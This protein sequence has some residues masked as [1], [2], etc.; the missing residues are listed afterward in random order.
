MGKTREHEAL[1]KGLD[2]KR[3]KPTFAQGRAAVATRR[4]ESGGPWLRRQEE[5][6]LPART[7]EAGASRRHRGN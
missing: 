2:R 6:M 5:A 4:G 1:G 7:G 3:S